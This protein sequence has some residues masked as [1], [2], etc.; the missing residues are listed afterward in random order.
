LLTCTEKSENEEIKDSFKKIGPLYPVLVD[1]NDKIIDGEHR[2]SIDDKWPT[3]L[4][5]QKST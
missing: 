3:Y 4:T 2:N 5:S 1:Y